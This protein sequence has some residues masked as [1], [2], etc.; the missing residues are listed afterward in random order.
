MRSHS[1]KKIQTM[2]YEEA[3]LYLEDIILR[4]QSDKVS[5]D[6]I[7]KFHSQANLYLNRC[8]ELL[9]KVEQEV[10]E[11]NPDTLISSK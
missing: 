7:Q 6:E 1:N 5:L 10:V 3:F 2:S 8:K 11:L 9:A 4:L